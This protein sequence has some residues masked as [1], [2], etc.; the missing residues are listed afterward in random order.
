MAILSGFFGFLAALL[1][2]IGLYGVIS[3]MVVRRRNEIGVR[4]VLGA[5]RGN[6]VA[7]ILREAAALLGVGIAIG[8]VL[9]V[10]AAT[11]ARALLFGLRP[12][13]PA[14]LVIA[15]ASLAAVAAPRAFCRLA[16][17][18]PSTPW[19]RPRRLTH[20]PTWRRGWS[21]LARMRAVRWPR[22][23]VTVE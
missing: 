8:A 15:A 11:S 5:T 6:V 19:R 17:R 2:M 14:T 12:S 1:A 20:S 23:T 16:A 3:Y 10:I 18:Q 22:S 13:D 9:A 4:M 7:M 21:P